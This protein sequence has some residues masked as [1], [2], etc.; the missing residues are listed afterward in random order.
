[1]S[2]W[3]YQKVLRLPGEAFGVNT[4]EDWNEFQEKHRDELS[5]N[6]RSFAPALCS[7]KNGYFI[8]YIISDEAPIEW[9]GYNVNSYHLSEFEKEK[10]LPVFRKLF[11]DFTIEQMDDVHLCEY[12]WY[13]GVEAPD[14]Y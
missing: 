11:P 1:M 6:E 3:R 12:S 4:K 14:C 9:E 10:Y 2:S 13:D 7:F 5:W 8:D